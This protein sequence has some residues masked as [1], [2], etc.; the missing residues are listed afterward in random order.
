[1]LNGGKTRRRL[2]KGPLEIGP[3]CAK[4]ARG[5]KLHGERG[6]CIILYRELVGR[7]PRAAW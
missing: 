6:G 2:E 4:V 3:T 1:M 5:S 7:L